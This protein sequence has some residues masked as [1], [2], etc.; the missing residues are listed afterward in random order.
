MFVW[1][2]C[3]PGV[4]GKSGFKPEGTVRNRDEAEAA[5]REKMAGKKVSFEESREKFR[6]YSDGQP[7]GYIYFESSPAELWV[8]IDQENLGQKGKKIVIGSGTLAD[9]KDLARKRV[10]RNLKKAPALAGPV[11]AT[12]KLKT[13]HFNKTVDNIEVKLEVE[14]KGYSEPADILLIKVV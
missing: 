2:Y 9:V 13:I 5:I 6:A 4:E 12:Q 7:T 3:Y 8:A 14:G 10:E 1:G 11:P